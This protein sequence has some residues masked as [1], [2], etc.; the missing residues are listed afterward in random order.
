MKKI[1]LT[2]AVIATTA[3]QALACTSMLVGKNASTDGSTI[4]S[5]AADSHDVYGYL[6][7]YPAA[8]HAKGDVRRIYDWDDMRYHGSIPEVAHTYSVVGNMN[9]H[10]LTITESTWGGHEEL[11]DTTGVIDYGSLIYIALQRAKTAREAIKVMTSLVAEYG[12]CSS[13]ES[14][15]I[16]DPNE[17]WVL[18]MIGKGGKEKGAVWVAIR[19]PDDCISCHANQSRIHKI[20]FKDKNNCMYSKDVVSFARKYGYYQG[21]DED[22]SFSKAY[23]EQ[24]YMAYRA[25]DLR[26]WA[27]FNRFVKGMDKYLPFCEQEKDA[28]VMP[29]YMKP[30]AKV[31]VHDIK[32]AMRDHYEGTPYDMTQDVGAGPYNS[33]YRPR[34]MTFKVDG[35]SYLHE[36]AIATQQTGFVLVAQMR[37]WMPNEVGGVLWF[38]VD[39]ANTNVFVPMYCSMDIIPKT[40][41]YGDLYHF[42]LDSAFWV[43][44]LIAN[45]AYHRYSLMIDD[46]RK[47]QSEIEGAFENNQAAI[48]QQALE[49]YKSQ[50][51]QAAAKFLN[52]YS[53]KGA[54]GATAK[55]RDLARFLFVRYLDGNKKK[56]DANGKFIYTPAGNEASP[57]HPAYSNERVYRAIVNERGDSLLVKEVK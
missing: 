54:D 45:Q 44:N 14:F 42:S 29:L 11:V 36:R 21:S 1:I 12:Y 48:E 37:S 38:G 24:D 41:G 28:E 3:M 53:V 50:S 19:I 20:P 22:F 5:Y 4:I 40:Y 7:R 51:P 57:E 49:L 23:A 39:D 9:E 16:G 34:P 35:K 6:C 10:Q 13:G 27:F 46:I 26:A 8:D 30:D 31:S 2:L 32:W 56:V 33:P 17:V 15:S 47:V 18:E 43:N 25:C 52:D 55:Y